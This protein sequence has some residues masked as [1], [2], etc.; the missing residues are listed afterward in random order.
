MIRRV[1]RRFR[2]HERASLRGM[3]RMDR[4]ERTGTGGKKIITVVPASSVIATQFDGFDQSVT[5]RSLLTRDE[6]EKA[7]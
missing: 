1:R 6:G 4:R 3:P 2:N 5:H 7:T